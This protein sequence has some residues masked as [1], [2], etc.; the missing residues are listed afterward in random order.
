ML[1]KIKSNYILKKFFSFLD[2]KLKLN[3][4]KYNKSL[5]K[6]LLNELDY[7][8]KISGRYL[9]QD[10]NYNYGKEFTLDKNILVY[11]GGY[12]NGKR[13]GKG[14]EYNENGIFKFE[15]EFSNGRRNGQGKEYKQDKDNGQIKLYFEGNYKNGKKNGKGIVYKYNKRIKFEGEFFNDLKEG[16]GKEYY[17]NGKIKF[18]GEYKKDK[19]WNGKGYDINGNIDYIISEGKGIIK[20]YKY[21]TNSLT[22]EGEY[23]NGEK[24]GKGKEYNYHGQLVF[25]GKYLNGKRHGQ[26]KEYLAKI[27]KISFEG[28]YKEG[29][30]WNGKGYDNQGNIIYELNNG[31]GYVKLYNEDYCY[32]EGE[33]KNG[34]ANGYGKSFLKMRFNGSVRKTFEGIYK[35][36]KQFEGKEYDYYDSKLIYEGTFKNGKYF[37]GKKLFSQFYD[38]DKYE[39]EYLNGKKWKGIEKIYKGSLEMEFEY[40]KGKINKVKGY[41][42]ENKEISFNINNGNGILKYYNKCGGRINMR[43]KNKDKIYLN[44]E[45]QLNDGEIKGIGKEYNEDGK[46][47]L[48]GEYCNDVKNGKGKIFSEKGKLIFEGEIYNGVKNGYGKDYFLNGKLMFEGIYINNEKFIGFNYNNKG[49]IKNEIK[50]GEEI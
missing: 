37:N 28:E 4:I 48:E 34:E 15:G 12:N 13:N 24:N 1:K 17:L 32:F 35:D 29:K 8:K 45:M 19:K 11:I 46:L 36:D 3:I 31:Q 21:S 40:I 42:P 23:K 41:N 20:L 27:N 10:N 2:V 39:G 14:V 25:G 33:Y 22:F 50:N 9:I 26:G 43:S 49:M 44:F 30:K 6:N 5:Q 38:D 16:S 7:F 18:E 47:I